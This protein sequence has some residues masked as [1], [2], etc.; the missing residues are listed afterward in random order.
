M[1]EG[2]RNGPVLFCFDGSDGSRAAMESR[3]I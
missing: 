3:W 1:T 2:D